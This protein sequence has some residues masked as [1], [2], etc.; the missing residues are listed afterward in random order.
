MALTWRGALCTAL[1]LGAYGHVSKFEDPQSS[2]F[3]LVALRTQPRRNVPLPAKNPCHGSEAQSGSLRSTHFLFCPFCRR[4]DC[5]HPPRPR[6][7]RVDSDS[8]PCHAQ[9]RPAISSDFWLQYAII[10]TRRTPKTS[11]VV[12]MRP[13]EPIGFS[14]RPFSEELIHSCHIRRHSSSG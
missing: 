13:A 11:F 8:Y 10:P 4:H 3:S 1:E 6:T 7:F 5:D 14:T 2:S 9:K 12:D